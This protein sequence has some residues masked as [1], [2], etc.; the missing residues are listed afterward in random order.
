MLEE[1]ELDSELEEELLNSDLPLEEELS[2][3]FELSLE[4]L[5]LDSSLL[6]LS[7]GFESLDSDFPL[8]SEE[9]EE[10]IEEELEEMYEKDSS[11]VELTTPGI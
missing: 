9:L 8:S 4:L 2:L 1:E 6:L 10:E 5:S 11:E 7:S 3:D